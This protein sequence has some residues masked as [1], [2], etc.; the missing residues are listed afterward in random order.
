[1]SHQRPRLVI[2]TVGIGL[3]TS[4]LESTERQLVNRYTNIAIKQPLP[5]NVQNVLQAGKILTKNKLQSHNYTVAAELSSLAAIFGWGVGNPPSLQNG[6]EIHLITT[7][8]HVGHACVDAIADY[9]EA[10]NINVRRITCTGLQTEDPGELQVALAELTKQLSDLVEGYRGS[11]EIICNVTGG[12]K[13]ISGYIQQTATLLQVTS[14]YLFEQSKSLI[15]IPKMP[16]TLDIQLFIDNPRYFAVMRQVSLDL[17]VDDGHSADE[18][19]ERAGILFLDK[20]IMDGYFFSAWGVVVWQA[21]RQRYYQTQ[22]FAPPIDKITYVDEKQLR[23]N[24]DRLSPKRYFDVNESIDTL[25]E[26]LIHG[27]E[28]LKSHTIKAISSQVSQYEIY[29]WNDHGT[30]RLYFNKRADGG[31]E[32][33]A[34]LEHL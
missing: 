18:L 25:A 21:I 14:C 33:L 20:S 4:G 2:S 30:G 22:L 16:I 7:D 11:H 28:P 9:F 32:I 8:T 12:F 24:L 13:A 5:D 26:W 1:M 29:A 23:K 27:K 19:I 10:H 3:V 15:Y 31:I 34:R 17:P 6:D